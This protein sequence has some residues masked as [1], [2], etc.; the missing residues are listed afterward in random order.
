VRGLAEI[1][2]PAASPIGLK[3]R[4]IVRLLCRFPILLVLVRHL[5]R[6]FS[7]ELVRLAP[8]EEVLAGR[9]QGALVP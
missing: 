9:C 4:F 7:V 1:L 6:H 3:S 5:T 8:R 2:H